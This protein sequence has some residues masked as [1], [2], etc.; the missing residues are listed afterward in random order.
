MREIKFRGKVFHYGNDCGWVY[1]DYHQMYDGSL[2]NYIT[3]LDADTFST[4]YYNVEPSTI[5]QYTGFKDKNGKEIYEGDIIGDW[6]KVDGELTQSKC[7]VYFDEK[8]G[9]YMLDCSAKQ[10]LS[11]GTSLFQELEDFEYEVIGN[12][13]ENPE[14]LK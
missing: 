6:T 9:Q 8:L 13:Y 7:Q 4:K 11:F 10:D 1:G 14:L 3:V 5:G 12:I 2:Y